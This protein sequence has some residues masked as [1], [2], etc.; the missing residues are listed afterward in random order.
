MKI[1]LVLL[2]VFSIAFVHF[3]GR[4][5]HKITRQLGDHS[6]FLAPVNVFLYLFS[7]LEAKPYLPVESFPELKPLQD[8]WQEIRAEAQQLLH[9]GEIKSSQNYD[10]VGFNS[11][12]KSGWKRFYLKW[13]GES[14]PS[15]MKLCPRTTELLQSIGTVKAAMFATLPPGSKLVRHRDPYAGSYRYHLGLDT[16]NDDA[17]YICVDG[18]NYSWRDGEGVV[19]DETYIHYASNQ[20]E[21]N[22]IILFCDVERP[23]KYRWA[24]AFNRWFSRSVMAA[25]AAPNDAGDKTGGINRLF[26]RI[27]KIRE[28]GKALK[29]RNRTRYYLEKWA[30]VAVLLLV[31]IYI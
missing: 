2:F 9:V 4:V 11:F 5:R 23:L 18:E 6:S 3:R 1:F 14:H 8:N 17:C 21:H 7:K 31:F 26:T 30:V 27:Y 16:P 12:F 24:T 10:D 29:K 22:R 13:Y 20:T 19:F 15:A 28:R 25:A